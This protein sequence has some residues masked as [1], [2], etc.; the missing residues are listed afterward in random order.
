MVV[1]PQLLLCGLF[2]ARDQMTNWLEWISNVLP[3]ELH[4]RRLATSRGPIRMRRA[5]M[6][7]RL[8]VVVGF[9]RGCAV[10]GAATLRRT[11]P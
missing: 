2:V 10:L 7:R 5:T 3:R 8:A 4:R 11:T 9:F 1:I 6:W